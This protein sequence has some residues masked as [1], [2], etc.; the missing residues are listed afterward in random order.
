METGYSDLFD[1][2]LAG[3]QST[4]SQISI[5]THR[6]VRT[7]RNGKFTHVVTLDGLPQ[8]SSDGKVRVRQTASR[9]NVRDKL[10]AVSATEDGNHELFFDLGQAPD[11]PLSGAKLHLKRNYKLVS[12][13]FVVEERSRGGKITQRHSMIDECHYS[14]VIHNHNSFSKVALSVC[15]GLVSN[16]SFL[17]CLSAFNCIAGKTCICFWGAEARTIPRKSD[18]YL[19]FVL[20]FSQEI[21]PFTCRASGF[22]F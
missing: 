9:R 1:R 17:S 21:L 19:G 20:I 7:T 14:G 2:A 12:E 3:F 11:S 6:P 5:H 10:D 13:N 8:V 18:Y 22:F 15:D 4:D 16:P